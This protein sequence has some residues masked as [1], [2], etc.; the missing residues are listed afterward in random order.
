V[1]VLPG[2]W[3]PVVETARRAGIGVVRIPLE[4]LSANAVNWKATLLKASLLAAWRVSARGTVRVRGA[5]RFYGVSLQ[6]GTQFHR[7]LLRFIDA[8]R[9]GTTELMVH[10][11]YVTADHPE[12]DLNRGQRVR[13]L[14]ALTSPDVRARIR[15]GDFRLTHFGASGAEQLRPHHDR[16]EDRGEWVGAEGGERR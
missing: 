4:P 11:G 8:L 5:A 10:P 14:S 3:A 6:H 15:R 7:R 9:E 1:H 12:Q 16:G 2:V 13:E